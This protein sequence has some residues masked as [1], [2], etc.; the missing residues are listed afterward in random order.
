VKS[1][2][3]RFLLPFGLLAILVSI[4][5]FYDAYEA[6]RRHAYQLLG[7]QAALALDFNLAI[8]EYA[9][10]RIRPVMAKLVDHDDFLPETMSTSFIARQIFEDARKKFPDLIVR[11][12]SDNPRNPLNRANPEEL[13]MIEY[14]RQNPSV[15]W[16]SE[17]IQIDGRLCL[18]HFTSKWFKPECMR[19]HGDPK[20]APAELVKRYGATASFHRRVG[21]VAGLDMVAVPLETVNMALASEMRSQSMMLAAALA[22]LFGSILVV[23]RFTVTRRLVAM[24]RHFNAIASHAESSS[25]TP[26]EVKGNDEITIV[27]LAFNKLIEQLGAAQASL[28][29]RVSE[30]TEE[31]REVNEQLQLELAARQQTTEALQQKTEELDRFF[32][33]ALDLLCI[34]H[35]DGF[36]RRINV[37]WEKTLGW[38]REELMARPFLEFVHPE[39]VDRTMAAVGMLASQHELIDFVNRYRC[40]D[41]TY[42]W[43]E[44]RSAPAGDLFFAAARDI[45]V[46]KRAGDALRES[47]ERYR[48]IFNNA[49][50]GILH[51]D[52]KGVVLDCNDRFAE[53]IGAARERLL[54]FN[55]LQSLRDADFLQAVKN[56][57]AGEVGYYEGDYVSVA[58]GKT[59][60]L[61]AIY[62]HMTSEDGRFLGAVGLFEDITE[63]KKTEEAL[64]RAEEKYRSIFENAIE[65]IFQT[66]FE[67]RIL[68]AN[69]ALAQ[70]LGYDSP[71]DAIHSMTDLSREYVNPEDRSELLQRIE[72]YG[73]VDG[74]ETQFLRKDRSVVWVSF[75][76][77][78]VR[79]S[80]GEIL[81]LEGTLQDISDRK[82]LE[83]RLIQSQ[84]MEAIGTLA[85]GIAHDFNNILAAIMGYAE[86]I[87]VKFNQPEL[88]NYLE[89]I[90]DSSCRARD[91][92]AQILTFS[93][94]SEQEQKRIDMASII[95]QAFK[96]LRATLPATI[97]FRQNIA[98]GVHAILADP[99]QIHQVLVNLGTNAAYAMREGGG[100]LHVGLEN[101][102]LSPQ[103]TPASVDLSPGSYV[104]LMVSDTGKGIAPEVMHR[105]FDPFFTTKKTGEGT[106]LGL[107]VVY[108]I[109]KGCGGTIVA[110]SE[111]GVG[112]VFTVYLP[113]IT[114]G[115]ELQVESAES[116]PGGTERILFVDDE[117]SLVDL[118]QMLLKD[119]GYRTLATTDSTKALEWFRK[120]PDQ[121]DLVVTDMTM[122]GMTGVELAAKMLR[123]R[124]DIPIILCTGFSEL[125]TEEKAKAMGIR[126][127]AMKPLNLQSIAQLLRKALV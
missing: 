87:K 89:Q 55:M 81:H 103:V 52:Q 41:G 84:K 60:P 37:A 36:L 66:T 106:G 8:R 94:G 7:Q 14:F 3:T 25:M 45:T 77:Y 32:S 80:R 22:L 31:W 100:V 42:R 64:A 49:P 118:W 105:I 35:T 10:E 43:I 21:D 30:R 93:R 62:K 47:E 38:S 39:D 116:V 57:L 23:F 83:I 74:F 101:V 59:T 107:S 123:I 69:P 65:G 68:S 70:I 71:A 40:K 98:T 6:S 97:T 54:G 121:F 85:G 4:L 90:L 26:V 58:G 91:L 15:P 72:K 78:A 114:H 33:I 11:F 2:S 44:W 56:A 67:G 86:I 82:S 5:M 73:R 1:L 79:D 92:V 46:H 120:Q 124:A 115:P 19:C 102:E 34:A 50:L 63:R 24:A 109:V 88:T 127:Y 113:A 18:A 29:L 122:P 111:L 27:G 95:N 20:D 119:L 99:T 96:M 125:I 48:L 117:D 75:N 108:G 104:K 110:E 28:E 13:R 61:R 51:F 16:R 76:I 12:P 53:I 9:A 17:E 112:S 126:E